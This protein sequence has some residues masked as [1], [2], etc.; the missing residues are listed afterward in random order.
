MHKGSIFTLGL[1]VCASAVEGPKF[2]KNPE[3]IT[4]FCARMAEG[5]IENDLKKEKSE[6]TNG[7]KLYAQL[8]I[9]GIRGEIENGLPAV[10]EG[11][12]VLENK[13]AEGKNYDE[14]SYYTILKIISQIRDTCL[15]SRG[16]LDEEKKVRKMASEILEIGTDVQDNI[17]KMD[18]YFIEKNLS[19][20]GD[21]DLLSACWFLH[22]LKEEV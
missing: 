4:S 15:I 16:G 9:S 17:I 11:L 12:T 6:K 7:E 5:L 22:F 18:K 14:A 2:W 1:L 20:G 19:P 21:A 3:R 13:I 8:G 10:R